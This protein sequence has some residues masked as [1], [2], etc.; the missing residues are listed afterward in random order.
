MHA[1][2][3][4]SKTV[5]GSEVISAWT[6]LKRRLPSSPLLPFSKDTNILLKAESLMP[7]GSF[8][9][10]GATYCIARMDIASRKRGVVA[11]STGNHA[12]AVAKAA[13]D[14]GIRATIVM[15]EDVPPAKMEATRSYGATVV[16]AACSSKSRREVAEKLALD[17]NATLIPPY[18][19]ADVIAGQ[20]TV[21]VELFH[22]LGGRKPSAVYI[23]V[24]GGGLLAGIAIAL[25]TLSPLTRVIGVEPELEDDACRSFRS[26]QLVTTSAPSASIA[27]A[28]KVQCLGTL[29]FP[30]I[31]RNV[32]QMVTVSE[33]AI[34]AALFDCFYGNRLV[35]E[36][37]G[38]IALAA[39][40]AHKR[41]D[42][43][44]DLAD[45]PVVAIVSGG[46]T[47]AAFL[48]QLLKG[49]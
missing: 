4:E 44:P 32:D 22:Q 29:N 31:K 49:E 5:D 6:L 47:T 2:S 36:P 41:E 11:Y 20:G 40:R 28:I 10:R 34:K 45:S 21:A 9:I 43:H 33:V 17:S 48:Q 42:S 16:M 30:L 26:R 8:K 19:H 35:V 18:D 24:G 13:C 38:A 3:S 27:D 46:N 25:R 15:S 39:A 37:S 14:A 7:T 23:P 12:Q 1:Q